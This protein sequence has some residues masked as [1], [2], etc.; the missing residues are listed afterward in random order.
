MLGL[1]A[2]QDGESPQPM[3]TAKRGHPAGESATKHRD[4]LLGMA[5]RLCRNTADAEDLTHEALL[6]LI[7]AHEQG[8]SI[9]DERAW[10]ARTLSRLLFNQCR[11]QKV[12]ARR[13]TDLVL[14]SE[15]T[16]EQQ[17]TP[18]PDYCSLTDE[19]LGQAVHS[20]SPKNRDAFTMHAAGKKPQEIAH[21]LGINP[22]AARKRLHDARKK[23]RKLLQKYLKPEVH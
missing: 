5:K 6:R 7:Q 22:T 20:L 8:E 12:Q 3:S 1:D 17:L 18:L 16:T 10:L 21:S 9:R 15:A 11:Q 23:L 2:K 19:Q 14:R 4:W 13:A